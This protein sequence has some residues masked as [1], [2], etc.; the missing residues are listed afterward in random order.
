MNSSDRPDHGLAVVGRAASVSM[1]AHVPPVEPAINTNDLNVITIIESR[2]P[3]TVGK[4]FDFG[5][6]GK[7]IK[8]QV[9]NIT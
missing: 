3:A 5:H 2:H 9:A 4:R 1:P 6:D 7:V 8:Q